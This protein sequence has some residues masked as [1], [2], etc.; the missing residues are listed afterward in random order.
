MST[1][2]MAISVRLSNARLLFLVDD[3]LSR[4]DGVVEVKGVVMAANTGDLRL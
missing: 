1:T 4:A 2:K 3:N